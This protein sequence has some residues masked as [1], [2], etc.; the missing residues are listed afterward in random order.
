ME[1]DGKPVEEA[2][3]EWVLFHKPP[4]VVTTRTDPQGRPTVYGLLP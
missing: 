4:G 2:A 1:L 3:P